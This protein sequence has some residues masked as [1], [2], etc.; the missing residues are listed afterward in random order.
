MMAQ[1]SEAASQDAAHEHDEDDTVPEEPREERAPTLLTLSR[2][3]E[4]RSQAHHLEP[5]V[6][7]GAQGLTPALFAALDEALDLH[8]LIK[9]RLGPGFVEDRHQAAQT[10][11]STSGA[12]LVQLIGRVVV[13][14]REPVPRPAAVKP[15]RDKSKN[16]R[17]V[18]RR[19]RER[20][21]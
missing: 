20:G 19:A 14:Y 5:V 7:V 12:A 2:R 10:L 18:K 1:D 6:Q 15:A 17:D 13:L 21:R 8:G 16:S 9:L 3:A 4:L 11:S